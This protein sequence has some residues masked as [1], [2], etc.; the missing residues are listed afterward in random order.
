MAIIRYKRIENGASRCFDKQSKRL[1]PLNYRG[2][3]QRHKRLF[4]AVCCLS[5][6]WAF[7]FLL[8]ERRF[9]REREREMN[10]TEERE[11]ENGGSS[12]R[13]KK[14]R[15]YKS[16]VGTSESRAFPSKLWNLFLEET[17]QRTRGKPGG[18]LSKRLRN[19]CSAIRMR[20][21]PF[22]P[23]RFPLFIFL[24]FYSYEISWESPLQIFCASFAQVKCI[25]FS[26]H[27]FFFRASSLHSIR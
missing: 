14:M 5:E 21:L 20:P 7:Q 15:G 19:N 11:R 22:H 1:I 6:S 25:I 9:Q 13:E 10:R 26:N 24:R 27:E 3:N 23:I 12:K 8:A 18:Y 2:R 4:P 16:V 17:Q